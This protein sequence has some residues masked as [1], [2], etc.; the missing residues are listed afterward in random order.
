[1]ASARS[2]VQSALLN[3]LSFF[4]RTAQAMRSRIEQRFKGQPAADDEYSGLTSDSPA[5][6]APV[7]RVA[8][9]PPGLCLYAIGDIHGRRDLLE[10]LIE[11]IAEDAAKLPAG[12]KPQVVFLGDYIDRGLQSKDVINYFI[13]GDLERFDPIYLMG[14][15]EEALLRFLNEATFGSQWTRYGGAE[16]LYSYGLAPPNQRASLGSHEEMAAVRD[17]WMRVWNEFR[18]RLPPEHLN[19]FQSLR[20]YYSIGD[21][22]FV[23]AGVRPG[24]NLAA[25]TTRD[26]LWIRE[27][28]LDDPEP[29]PQMVVHGHTPMDAVH[30]DNRRIGLDTGAFLTGK[31][32]AARLHGTDVAFLST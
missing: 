3:R 1:M 15:H 24:V 19:F 26:M 5:P 20:P 6:A 25:Q 17:A 27:E 16:T 7:T 29:F 32:T 22:L 9:V 21:Y 31:L 12:V 4:G 28:F 11:Q 18:T 10:R 2:R 14:N 13:N 8:A 23:H 30:Y